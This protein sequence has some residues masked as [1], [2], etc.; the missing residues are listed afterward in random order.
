[1]NRHLRHFAAVLAKDRGHYVHHVNDVSFISINR[2]G[3]EA[4]L[5]GELETG[6]VED[7]TEWL[8]AGDLV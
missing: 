2:R 1:M 4:L 7:V 3:D 5:I 6:R 8:E